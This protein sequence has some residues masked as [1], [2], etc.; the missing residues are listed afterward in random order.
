MK[1]GL[2]R[3]SLFALVCLFAH[4]SAH[5]QLPTPAGAMI[6][7]NQPI[8][9]GKAPHMEAKKIKDASGEQVYVIIFHRD[10]D[11]LSGLT[12]FVIQNKIRNGHFTAIGAAKNAILGWLDLGEKAYHSI[13]VTQQSEVLSLIGDVAVYK[14]KPTIHAH[15]VLSGP[16]GSTI[17]GHVWRLVVDPTLEVFLTVDA[18]ELIK[19]P[20][21]ASGLNLIDAGH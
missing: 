18:P 11:A 2:I 5:A 10:D 21:N 8:E 7:P 20:D 15:A 19:K 6:S 12:D 16:S 4:N 17:G 9:G 14:G 13:L 3:L 1:S